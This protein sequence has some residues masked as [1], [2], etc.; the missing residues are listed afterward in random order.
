MLKI[1]GVFLIKNKVY[2]RKL[3]LNQNYNVQFMTFDVN[4]Y[5][6]IYRENDPGSKLDGTPIHPTII[7]PSVPKFKS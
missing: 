7:Q 4:M 2:S 3:I 5:Q 6:N 1:E